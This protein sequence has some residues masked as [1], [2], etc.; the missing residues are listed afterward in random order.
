MNS[1]RLWSAL[2]LGAVVAG[3]TTSAEAGLFG[4]HRGR[5]ASSCCGA[6]VACGVVGGHYEDRVIERTV[7]V[8][9]TVMETRKVQVTECRN[10]TRERE[11]QCT[12][13][14]PYQET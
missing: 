12:R 11:V 3:S 13:R 8:N 1:S 10:E 4:R 14:V 5:G 6:P 2:L 9:E 7:Y